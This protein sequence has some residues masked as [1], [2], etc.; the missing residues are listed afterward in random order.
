MSALPAPALTALT[1]LT[2]L[3]PLDGRYEQKVARLREYFS[4]FALIKFR[5]TVEVAWLIALAASPEIAECPPF[6]A[7]TLD[8]LRA[9]ATNFSVDDAARV[10]Q[11]EATTNHD[12]KAVEYWL[13]EKFASN[14]E[15]T[16]AQA[17]IHFACTSEDINNLSHALMLTA[18]REQVMLPALRR[19]SDKL[20]T[21]AHAHADVGML[22]H[23]H[24][25]AASPTTL[26]K[27]MANVVARLQRA[28]HQLAEVEMLGKMNGAVGNYNAH[29]AAYP[30]IDW[31][32]FSK[33]VVEAL[34]LTFNPYTTQI[35]PH[36][37]MAEMFDA[38]ARI[39]T[40]LIDLNRDIWGYISL[41]YF[42]QIT[43]AGEIGS[44]TMPHKVNPIDFEN[45][46]GNLGL[47]N[48]LLRH[49][50]EKLPISRWQRDLTDS[51]VLRNM[52]VAF[53]YSL[54]AYDSL[55]RGLDKLEINAAKIAAALEA[56]WDVLAEPIQTVMRKYAINDAYEQLKTLTRGKGGIDRDSLQAFIHQLAI[57]EADKTRLLALTPGSYTGL[58]SRLAKQ[59]R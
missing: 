38:I 29:L 36:D 25:Q 5:V 21:L 2:A 57:P 58:A 49:M 9:A 54:L 46:E 52:G 11:I 42:K 24:G 20:K 34:G 4:E 8:A 14:A 12:V 55:A 1:A 16:D 26:G 39:N 17:F 47:A 22:S 33:R 19:V 41:G 35:E 44:S 31:P 30:D 32:G 27:E 13:R 23:T 45:S 37:Y 59:I 3:S 40:I 56:N 18:A 51:T 15:I 6:T 43:K 53:G 50:A 48:A 28:V 7:S 10:K